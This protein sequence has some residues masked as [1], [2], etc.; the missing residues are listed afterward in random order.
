MTLSSKFQVFDIL[1]LLL[2]SLA[3]SDARHYILIYHDNTAKLVYQILVLQFSYVSSLFI[4]ITDR[5][6]LIMLA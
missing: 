6:Q 5:D 3:I 2:A 4:G 1:L